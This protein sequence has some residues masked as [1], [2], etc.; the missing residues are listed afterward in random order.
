M[1]YNEDMYAGYNHKRYTHFRNVPTGE[2][3]I[4]SVRT[5]KSKAR[6]K[7]IL[8]KVKVSFEEVKNLTL[9]DKKKGTFSNYQTFTLVDNY[10]IDFWGAILGDSVVSTYLHL[11]RHAYNEKDFCYI[12]MNLIADKMKKDRKTIKGYLNKLEEKGFIAVFYRLDNENNNR[13][14]SPLFKLR[15]TVPILSQEEY[16]SL[17]PKL[18]KLHDEYIDRF[19]LTEIETASEAPNGKTTKS[20]INQLVEKG[21]VLQSKKAKEKAKKLSEAG[22]V[23]SYI[24]S[25]MTEKQLNFN[26]SMKIA[27]SEIVSKPSYDTWIKDS[28]FISNPQ[29]RIMILMP[30]EFAK[31]WFKAHY[32]LQVKQIASTLLELEESKLTVIYLLSTEYI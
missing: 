10:L 8:E 16:E 19:S 28:I 14:V 17:S 7:P 25:T 23:E 31:D 5:A 26:N 18:R 9:E 12:D 27:F 15:V 1:T 13:E 2:K 32:A 20:L 6:P 21:E 29:D 11:R 24:L 4:Q 22:K 3:E 30:N